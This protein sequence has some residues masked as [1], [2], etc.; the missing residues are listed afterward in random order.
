M[1]LLVVW[2]EVNGFLEG[3]PSLILVAQIEVNET[4]VKEVGA[5]GWGVFGDLEEGV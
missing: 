3:E 4:D 2:L 1:S 5:F